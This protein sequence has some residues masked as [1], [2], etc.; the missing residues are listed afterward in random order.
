MSAIMLDIDHF[1]TLNDSR[2]HLAG[3][4]VLRGIAATLKESLRAS[5]IACRWGGE[6]FLVILSNTDLAAAAKVATT[7]CDRIAKNRYAFNAGVIVVTVSAGVAAYRKDETRESFV[8][9]VDAL[10]YQAK[11]EGRNRVCKEAESEQV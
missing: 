11:N 4:E 8:A 2:G 5:D 3:D 7:L 6:E 9:R 1:K 10:L